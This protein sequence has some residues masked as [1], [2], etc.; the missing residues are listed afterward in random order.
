[1]HI[2]IWKAV[3][4]LG[5][6]FTVGLTGMG[7]GAL[8]TPILVLVFGVHPA[9]AV[10]SDLLTSLVM[11]PVGGMVHLRR[12]TIDWPLVGW[13][14]VGSV[15]AAFAGVF[16][17]RLLGSGPEVQARI[18]SL[19]GLALMVA[20]T[21]MI[22]KARLGAG[23]GSR[24]EPGPLQL[25]R[26][27]TLSIGMAGGLLV[28]ATSVG[29]GSLMMV[30]LLLVYPRLSAKRLVGTDLVQAVPLVGAA[31]ISHALFGHIDSGLAGS[32]LMGS[33]PGAYLGARVSSRAPDAVVRPV[34]VV[35]LFGSALKL[36]GVRSGLLAFS[37]VI[38]VIVA[39]ASI[40][41]LRFEAST[42]V[43]GGS[44]RRRSCPIRRVA[45]DPPERR[46]LQLARRVAGKAG[47]DVDAPGHRGL[48]QP[49]PDP[50]PK[51]PFVDVHPG[52]GNDEGDDG[53]ERD[54]VGKADDAGV[55]HRG[56]IPEHSL[57]LG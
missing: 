45:G 6:G 27:A 23:R 28:G 31:T 37:V 42:E 11:K 19:L 34:L 33:V 50:A 3:A 52:P 7:G 29:S 12:G 22:A 25:K 15:P 48:R 9:T 36:L 41:N 55:V 14:C 35:I 21:A 38:V 4:G 16:V 26:V 30:L 44:P 20:A 39:V 57:H 40:C 32:L 24:A 13:L 18:Q 53:L 10:S 8:M 49:V 51:L 17:V 56:V 54:G 5:V 2:E 47:D 1:M 43:R 46:F